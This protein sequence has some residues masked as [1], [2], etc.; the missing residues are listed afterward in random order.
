MGRWA[1]R[2]KAAYAR[3]REKLE[4]SPP[5]PM[6]NGE[7]NS[8]GALAPSVEEENTVGTL[9][10]PHSSIKIRKESTNRCE[11]RPGTIW[12]CP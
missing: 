9:D 4:D 11:T 7:D 10:L 12:T 2:A 5:S 1:E 8:R 6:P 3:R